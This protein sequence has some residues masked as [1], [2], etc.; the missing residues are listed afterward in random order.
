MWL[1]HDSGGFSLRNCRPYPSTMFEVPFLMYQRNDVRPMLV[2]ATTR[3]S[4][5]MCGDRKLK[6][7][8][9]FSPIISQLGEMMILL[10]P[11]TNK[12]RSE[13][14]TGISTDRAF[15][16]IISQLVTWRT[17]WCPSWPCIL[18]HHLT[19]R[20]KAGGHAI[21]SSRC[22]APKPRTKAS[23]QQQGASSKGPSI[24]SGHYLT[25]RNIA[26]KKS[27]VPGGHPTKNQSA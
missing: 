11:A 19:N 22:L 10:A 25:P 17:K 8:C 13:C 5:R 18:S 27:Q 21:P 14:T 1:G 12:N 24:L 4:K 6:R 20:N 15:S 23:I 2:A 16:P 9:A 3:E 26:K 7:D